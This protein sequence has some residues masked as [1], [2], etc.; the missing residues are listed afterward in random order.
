M[1][2]AL[3]REEEEVGK[4]KEML[5]NLPL[6]QA[7]ISECSTKLNHGK[8]SF[9]A[10]WS[11]FLPPDTTIPG[12]HLPNPKN[13]GTRG[14][15]LDECLALGYGLADLAQGTSWR[16]KIDPGNDSDDDESEGINQKTVNTHLGTIDQIRRDLRHILGTV[17]ISVP[18]ILSNSEAKFTALTESSAPWKKYVESVESAKTAKTAETVKS[19]GSV[20]AAE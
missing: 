9:D 3:R 8:N 19:V 15:F 4:L 18:D 2:S 11:H 5:V 13:R 16:S 1:K 6:S 7:Q 12:Y 14:G 20:E 17:E 10:L